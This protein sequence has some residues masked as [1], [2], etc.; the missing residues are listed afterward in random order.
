M[1]NIQVQI[2]SYATIY[3]QKLKFL[4]SKHQ[5]I[6]DLE[7]SMRSQ[8]VSFYGNITLSQRSNQERSSGQPLKPKSYFLELANREHH[9]IYSRGTFLDPVYPHR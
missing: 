4:G 9:S 2:L 1:E 3:H 5:R 8:G 7:K 6:Q